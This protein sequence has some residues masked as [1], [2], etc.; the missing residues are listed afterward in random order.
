MFQEK[1]AGPFVYIMVDIARENLV[2]GL[3]SECL[4]VYHKWESPETV[5][6]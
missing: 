2:F 3:Q 5:V 6:K 4:L 1:Q